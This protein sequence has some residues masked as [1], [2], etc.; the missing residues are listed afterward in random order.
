MGYAS[1][2][3]VILVIALSVFSFVYVKVVLGKAE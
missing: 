2:L 3:A 1:A